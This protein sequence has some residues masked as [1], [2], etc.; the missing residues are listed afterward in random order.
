MAS[1]LLSGGAHQGTVLE[2]VQIVPRTYSTVGEL[3]LWIAA[4]S[5]C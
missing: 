3:G 4:A 1:T 2:R 5:M